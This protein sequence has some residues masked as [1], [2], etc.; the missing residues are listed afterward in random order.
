MT[1]SLQPSNSRKNWKQALGALDSWE[2]QGACLGHSGGRRRGALLEVRQRPP[3]QPLLRSPG[4]RCEQP[5]SG[6][7]GPSPGA[8][9]PA[10]AHPPP[11]RPACSPRLQNRLAPCAGP[12][13]TPAVSQA[14]AQCWAGRPWP[15]PARGSLG[16][17]RS[18]PRG[19][20][21]SSP[22]ASGPGHPSP[23]R[24]PTGLCCLSRGVPS[25]RHL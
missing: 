5:C 21:T 4:F 3:P 1:R 9:P 12:A 2:E 15:G 8:A 25:S 16:P 22:P 19:R 7:P 14:W 11:P 17:Q 20:D 23:G 24:V 6:A 18:R 10:S 13:R